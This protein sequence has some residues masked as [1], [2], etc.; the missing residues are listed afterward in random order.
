[1]RPFRNGRLWY[2]RIPGGTHF[3]PFLTRQAARDFVKKHKETDNGH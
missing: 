3:V 1:M 2:V